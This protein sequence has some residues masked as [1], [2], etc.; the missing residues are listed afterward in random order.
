MPQFPSCGV[1]EAIANLDKDKATLRAIL[2]GLSEDEF[3]TKII[4]VPWGWK[5]KMEKMALDFR[6]H[7]VHHKMQL[8]TYLKLLG[9]PVNTET[10]YMG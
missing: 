5:S 9:L 10:L 7:F 6:D 4:S 1:E 3:A 8:F 2:D